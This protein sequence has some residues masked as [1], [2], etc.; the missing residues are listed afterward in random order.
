MDEAIEALKRARVMHQLK[1]QEAEKEYKSIIAQDMEDEEF[2]KTKEQAICR[3]GDL[4]AD[5]RRVADIQKLMIDVRP[6]FNNIPKAKTA[7]IVRTLIDV[8][9]KIPGSE[10]VQLQLCLDTIEWCKQE[11]RTFLRHRI[12]TRL[13]SMYFETKDYT[14]ALQLVDE[15]LREVKKLDDKPLLVEIHLVESRTHHQ[16]R[17]LPKSKAALT[18][19]RT[20]AN[21]IYCPPLLQAQIDTQAGTLHAEEKD[22]KTAYSYFFEA[23]EAFQS[24]EDPR[25]V[26]SLK[27]MLL[28]KIM[29]NASD[30]VTGLIDSKYALKNGSSKELEAMRAIAVAYKERSLA[31]LIDTQELYTEELREDPVTKFHLDN[32]YNTLLEQN[33]SRL[34]EPFSQVQIAHVADLI[35]LPVE[36]VETTL[37]QMILDKKFNG[38]LDQGSGAL[39]AYEDLPDNATLETGLET[40]ENMSK[41]VDSLYVRAARLS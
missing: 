15:L 23:M 7:K 5:Q 2:N 10:G 3:L 36:T 29:T 24:Q 11:K 40:I 26:K 9:A 13:A 19:A 22:Y 32:L 30:E 12:Q 31:K 17:N 25:F 8:M 38:I 6:F 39:I 35:K 4:Y 34:I 14:K 27:H 41:V 20:A 33:L 18:S 21:S 28:C 37:S 16:L 1:P